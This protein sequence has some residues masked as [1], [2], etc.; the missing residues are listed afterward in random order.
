MF[1]HEP[2]SRRVSELRECICTRD[3]D[4]ECPRVA[5]YYFEI[6]IAFV[7]HFLDPDAERAQ[8]RNLSNVRETLGT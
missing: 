8:E 5:R 1:E 4:D 6:F 2:C 3:N 7:R